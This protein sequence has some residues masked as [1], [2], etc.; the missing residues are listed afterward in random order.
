[1]RFFGSLVAAFLPDLVSCTCAPAQ[2]RRATFHDFMLD[3][4][5]RLHRS[6]RVADPLSAVAAQVGCSEGSGGF[7]GF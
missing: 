4:H 1:M 3:V 6:E 2:L 5:A 7:E